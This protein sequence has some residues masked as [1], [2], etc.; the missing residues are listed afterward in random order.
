MLPLRRLNSRATPLEVPVE[1][2]E[3]R[4]AGFLGGK[5]VAT[6]LT[7]PALKEHDET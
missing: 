1:R 7:Y 4:L 3:S 5:G 2:L 6:P